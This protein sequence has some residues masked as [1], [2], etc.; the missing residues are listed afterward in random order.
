[1]GRML[2]STMFL[3]SDYGKSLIYLCL[4]TF[5]I[6]REVASKEE[7]VNILI[8]RKMVELLDRSKEPVPVENCMNKLQLSA[9]MVS[10]EH[11][12]TC[13]RQSRYYCVLFYSML[14]FVLIGPAIDCTCSYLLS[15]AARLKKS[16]SKTI[17]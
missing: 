9:M 4:T 17:S 10:G 15:P 12:V 13:L 1:M 3:P 16:S 5:C 11:L 8:G 7:E 2:H 14:T 6:I